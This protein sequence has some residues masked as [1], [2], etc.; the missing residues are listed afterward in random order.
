MP[1]TTDT[2]PCRFCGVEVTHIE[3]QIKVKVFV[4]VGV[5]YALCGKKCIAS[6]VPNEWPNELWHG[7]EGNCT[8]CGTV[9]EASS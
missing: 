7:F 2:R 6:R 9:V 4:P 1:P 5:H 3:V 8:S